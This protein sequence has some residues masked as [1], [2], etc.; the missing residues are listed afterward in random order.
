MS[1]QSSLNAAIALGGWAAS[2]S[3]GYE[4]NMAIA[5]SNKE[6]KGTDIATKSLSQGE[7]TPEKA[8]AMADIAQDRAN[9]YRNLIK[10]GV[11]DS[12]SEYASYLSGADF[13]REIADELREEQA[14]GVDPNDG[15]FGD[16]QNLPSN[17]QSENVGN[18]T[19]N[20]T[21]AP[22]SQN[23]AFGGYK[24]D[25]VMFS[26]ALEMAQRAR[27]NTEAKKMQMRMNRPYPYEQYRLEVNR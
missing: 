2:R 17:E 21:N 14:K 27:D 4:R 5:R 9:A 3:F 11:K 16:A 20:A 18:Y 6:L 19:P 25:D 24:Y 7:W 10:Y 8:T 13:H 15:P 12:A 26:K 23:N 1:I 22:T